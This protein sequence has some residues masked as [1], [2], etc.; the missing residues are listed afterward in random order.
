[1]CVDYTH[2]RAEPLLSPVCMHVFMSLHCICSSGLRL[3]HIIHNSCIEGTYISYSDILFLTHTKYNQCILAVFFFLFIHKQSQYIIV[4]LFPFQI[5]MTASGGGIEIA[6]HLHA[7]I[8][9]LSTSRGESLTAPSNTTRSTRQPGGS[10]TVNKLEISTFLKWVARIIAILLMMAVFVFAV[11]SKTAFVAIASRLYIANTS[12]ECQNNIEL[13]RQRSVAFVQLML[14]LCVPQ[15][16]T[17][18]RTLFFGVLKA[19]EN[20]PWPTVKACITVS[21]SYTHV[22]HC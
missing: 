22:N 6:D 5:E 17:A 4:L 11:L 15:V 12:T 21:G 13:V 9:S 18:L 19:N 10:P 7:S 16:I 8:N 2:Y 3:P 1:M 14:A 20:F